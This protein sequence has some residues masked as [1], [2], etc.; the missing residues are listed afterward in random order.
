[1]EKKTSSKTP[2]IK[3]DVRN[4]GTIIISIPIPRNIRVFISI[5]LLLLSL[6][7]IAAMIITIFPVYFG[8]ISRAI[9]SFSITSVFLIIFIDILIKYRT[10]RMESNEL[11]WN[12]K[13]RIQSAESNF[14]EDMDK[15]ITSLFTSDARR[16]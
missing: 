9:F 12:E 1:M 3:V 8:T 13:Q 4:H 14:F 7:I 16:I 15:E 2:Q 10:K 6:L 11:S 5:F